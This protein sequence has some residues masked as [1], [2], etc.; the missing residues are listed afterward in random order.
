MHQAIPG[1][2]LELFENCG[3]WPQHEQAERYNHLSLGFLRKAS[4]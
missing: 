4:A 2:Q 1:S 3:H